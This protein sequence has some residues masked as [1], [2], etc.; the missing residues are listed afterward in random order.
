MS[1]FIGVMRSLWSDQS[2]VTA[3]EYG[4]IAALIAGVI[5][6][7]ITTFGTDLSSVFTTL[8]GKLTTANT[9]AGG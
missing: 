9:A 7:A 4:L 6:A 5:V 3:V 8:S 1:A 2:G